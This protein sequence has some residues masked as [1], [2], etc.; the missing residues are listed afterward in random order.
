VTPSTVFEP[1]QYEY[2]V[3]KQSAKGSAPAAAAYQK[4]E[5]VAGSLDVNPEYQTVRF[6]TY[7]NRYYSGQRM[8]ARVAGGGELTSLAHPEAILMLAALHL[9]TDTVTGASD[10]YQHVLTPAPASPWCAFYKKAGVTEGSGAN[11]PM[12]QRYNDC[13][14][15]QFVFEA[16]SA[17]ME[18]RVT[19]RVL[20]ADP[21]EFRQSADDPTGA[22][23][24]A[25]DRS[26]AFTDAT[27]AF[28]FAGI[29]G[30][31]I[32]IPSTVEVRLELNDNFNPAPG[33]GIVPLDFLAGESTAQ[34]RLACTANT[35]SLGELYKI[36]YGSAA[37]AL[38]AK[39][40]ATIPPLGSVDL[41]FTMA[42]V[43]PARTLRLE[44]A[45]VEFSPEASVPTNTT[46]EAVS[47]AFAG[48]A[49][50]RASNPMVKITGQSARSAA[51]V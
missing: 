44:I 3:A 35:E 38:G 31:A 42:G 49:R 17:N 26:F 50:L 43:T 1:S 23:P 37:P 2:A 18:G 30:T 33:D 25:A 32:V 22:H 4:L 15:E 47:L 14:V 19:T 51:Y 24:S 41:L 16:S 27:G 34:V 29:S 11:A 28:K 21:G 46:G 8:L 5:V 13:R 36:M 39:P 45:G 48:E 6:P 7:G 12:R 40:Q 9:G 10:P 20:S